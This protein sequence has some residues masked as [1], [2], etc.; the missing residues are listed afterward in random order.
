MP[1]LS[2]CTLH[3]HTWE[4]RTPLLQQ[5]YQDLVLNTSYFQ[6]G[7]A[8]QIGIL[9]LLHPSRHKCYLNNANRDMKYLFYQFLIPSVQGLLLLNP[10][11]VLGEEMNNSAGEAATAQQQD[12]TESHTQRHRTVRA[13]KLDVHYFLK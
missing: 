13:A 1:Q 10:L 6:Q 7:C 9:H 8:I 5:L 4:C 12:F 3:R 2:S 11:H